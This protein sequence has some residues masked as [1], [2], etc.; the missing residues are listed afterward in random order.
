VGLE[1]RPLVW[2]EIV[3]DVGGRVINHVFAVEFALPEESFYRLKQFIH[4]RSVLS[5]QTGDGQ[6]PLP[7]DVLDFPE[8]SSSQ[9]HRCTITQIRLHGPYIQNAP[10]HIGAF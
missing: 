10:I 4:L 1:C 5:W 7:G 8:W 3:L 2:F 6:H 9:I